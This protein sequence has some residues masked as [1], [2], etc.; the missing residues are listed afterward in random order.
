MELSNLSSNNQPT[1]PL[2]TTTSDKSFSLSLVFIILIIALTSGFFLSRFI[3]TKKIDQVANSIAQKDVITSDKIT[4]KN[5][6]EVGKTY[7][8]VG[9]VFSDSATGVVQSGNIN[10]EGTH[11]LVRDGGLSQR[12]SLMSSNLDLDLF[13]NHKVEVKGQTNASNKTGW[14]MDV[15]TIKVLE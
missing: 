11:I 5:Q 15:G 3:P 1:K 7:G 12:V 2:N 6:I 13:I 10:G 4:D 14:L 9:K 8:N